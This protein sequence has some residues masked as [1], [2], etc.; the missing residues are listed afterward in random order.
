MAILDPLEPAKYETLQQ[1]LMD[2]LD[3]VQPPERLK[4]SEAA[5]KFRRL[6]NPGAYV[7]PWD[8]TKAPYL[9]EIMDTLDSEEHTGLVVAGPARTGKSDMLFNWLTKLVIADPADM[10]VIH[11][12]QNTARDWSKAEFRKFLRDTP[13]AA[14]RLAPGRDSDNVFDKTFRSMRVLNK[15]PSVKELSGKTVRYVW[16]ND[17]DRMPTNVE[18][19]GSPWALGKKR[20]ETFGRY[21]MT[22]AEAS[23]GFPCTEPRWK[24]ST[25]HMAPPTEGISGLYNQGDRRRRYWR[26]PYCLSWFEP[27]FDLLV[28][29]DGDDISKRASQTMLQCPH[30]TCGKKIHPSRKNELDLAGVWLRDGQRLLRSTDRKN[31]IV[32]EGEGAQSDIASFWIPAL[33]TF[34]M[35]WANLV[36]NYLRAEEHFRL[37][38][39]DN[40]LKATTTVD[41]GCVYTPRILT[42]DVRLPEVI[43]A[44]CAEPFGS[45]EQPVVLDGVRFLLATVDVQSNR[46]IVQIHGFR[47][48]LEPV[49]TGLG[50]IVIVDRFEI[51]KSARLDADDSPLWI[52]PA[53]F[54]E[55]WRLIIERV[56]LKRY[57]LGDGSGRMMQV[58]QTAVDSGGQQGVTSKAY[59]FWRYL[60]DGPEEDNS[61]GWYPDAQN[62]LILVKG[63][64]GSRVYR[65]KIDYPDSVSKDRFSGAR[66]E[67]PVMFVN[68]TAMKDTVMG[69][70]DR[71]E[72]GGK[73]VTPTWFADDW[74]NELLAEVRTATRWENPKNRRNESLD[75]LGYAYALA[76]SLRVQIEKIDWSDPPSWAAEWNENDMVSGEGEAPRFE[77]AKTV[78]RKS[79]RE[80]GRTLG[81]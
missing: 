7:G 49:N 80:L 65:Q 79:L 22:V 54:L 69:M 29:P 38:N 11:M 39:D 20:T 43:K 32:I 6:N 71:V 53:S 76:L 25:P 56:M 35:S 40:Q 73:I 36:R 60:R 64:S 28:Y 75:L 14:A 26:C 16:F 61:D 81:K 34:S 47:R 51:Q 23:P 1:V 24:P 74:Y 50:D 68:V 44:N 70:A 9:V 12:K 5:A 18:G 27:T 67:V 37:T 15:W 3:A 19:E 31:L 2:C 62:R 55:D 33:A 72:A 10:M 21:G 8:N 52:K 13:E 46:F 66:G 58:L 48:P 78:V 41:Q 4:V 30:Q 59:D 42:G 17:F 63:E 45:A 77:Q 57:P